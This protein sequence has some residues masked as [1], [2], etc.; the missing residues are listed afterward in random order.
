MKAIVNMPFGKVEIE[1]ADAKEAI[2]QALSIGSY[3]R[4]C[5]LCESKVFM[6]SNRT[7]EGHLYVKMQCVNPECKATANLGTLKEN[8]GYFWHREFEIYTPKEK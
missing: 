7:T 8:K 2:N 6:R 5:S 1:D 4:K 3:P